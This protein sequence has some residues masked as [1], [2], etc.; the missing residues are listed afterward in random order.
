MP[1][2]YFALAGDTNR[3]KIGCSGNVLK[4]I[5]S[6]QTGCPDKI[7]VIFTLPNVHKREEKRLHNRFKSSQI[8]REWFEYEPYVAKFVRKQIEERRIV[9]EEAIYEAEAEAEHERYLEQEY[10]K[11]LEKQQQELEDAYA[12]E[13]N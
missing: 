3:V 10:E 4:R 1:T 11:Y 5:R 9:V 6:L 13:N 2:V 12:E 7:R 8:H